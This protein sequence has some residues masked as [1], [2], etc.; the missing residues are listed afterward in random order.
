MEFLPI[1]SGA[2]VGPHAQSRFLD[3]S[4]AA[5]VTFYKDWDNICAAVPFGVI[6]GRF[7]TP[8]L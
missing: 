1:F 2:A 7:R 8:R 3:F 4:L 5:G 6:D